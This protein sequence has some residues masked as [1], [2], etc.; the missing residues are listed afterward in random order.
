MNTY[1][2]Y[3]L[4]TS[5]ALEPK[6]RVVYVRADKYGPAWES[7]RALCRGEEKNGVKH[8][9]EDQAGE[10]IATITAGDDLNVA[11][12]DNL[13]KRNVKLDKAALQA[14]IDSDEA[15]AEEKVEAMKALIG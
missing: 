6:A 1:R 4:D 15:T 5:V 3:L 11:K 12:I 8:F 9:F 10:V 7:A 13:K 14:I 2:V